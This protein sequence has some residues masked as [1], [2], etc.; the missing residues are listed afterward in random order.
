MNIDIVEQVLHLIVLF[1][2]IIIVLV[3]PI[4][5]KIKK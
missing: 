3:S 2:T 4:V 5:E 1:G